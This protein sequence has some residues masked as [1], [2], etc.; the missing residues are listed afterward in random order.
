[1]V[2]APSPCVVPTLCVTKCAR[3]RV[4]CVDSQTCHYGVKLSVGESPLRIGKGERGTRRGGASR[5]R[6]LSVSQHVCARKQGGA[7]TLKVTSV[8]RSSLS[9]LLQ[10]LAG[11]KYGSDVEVYSSNFTQ[12]VAPQ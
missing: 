12:S 2:T 11:L 7:S 5:G 1:M 6:T 8:S 3:V 10:D 4:D 9:R